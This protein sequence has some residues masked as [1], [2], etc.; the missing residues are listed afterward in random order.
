[1]ISENEYLRRHA[2]IREHMRKDGMDCLLVCGLAA[3]FHRGN[4]RYVTGSGRGGQCIFPLEERPV[5]LTGVNQSTS[6]KLV[7]T[8]GAYELL[9][10]VESD[11]PGE[12]INRELSRF[13]HGG[14][15]GLVGMDCLPPGAPGAAAGG[16]PYSCGSRID[17]KARKAGNR[18]P[19]RP[20]DLVTAPQV[21]A[22]PAPRRC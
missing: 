18:S 4:I 7:K 8:V 17:L 20:G 22:F 6:P 3:D 15:I 16:G 13:D 5:L 11:K 14:K 1:M 21:R 2:S 9:E 10:F 12:T 19:P